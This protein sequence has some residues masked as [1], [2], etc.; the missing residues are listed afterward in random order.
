MEEKAFLSGNESI[1]RG[2]YEGGGVIATGCPGVPITESLRTI[3]EKYKN[4][5]SEMSINENVALEVSIGASIAGARA[6]TIM[7]HT[8]LNIALDSL[9][10]FTQSYINGGF[11]IAISS[12]AGGSNS[13]TNQDV[14][15]LGKYASIGIFAPSNQQE[16]KDFIKISLEVSEKYSSPIMLLVNTSICQ[17][18]SMVTLKNRI[19]SMMK[20]FIPDQTKY[21]MFPP[22]LSQAQSRLRERVESL[23]NYAYSCELNILEEVS[24][25][26]TLIIT[27][28]SLY[29]LLKEINPKVSIYKLGCIYPISIKK[30]KELSEK[31]TNIIIL[32]ES[33]PFIENE[34]KFKGIQCEGKKYFS[35]DGTFEIEDIYKG[36]IDAGVIQVENTPEQSQ[37]QSSEQNSQEGQLQNQDSEENIGESSGENTG[38]IEDSS[39][40]G[41]LQEEESL[42]G[43]TVTL[44]Q[45]ELS[46]S[47]LKENEGD[48]K[49]E[50]SEENKDNVTE[51]IKEGINKEGEDKKKQVEETAGEIISKEE[52]K[53]NIDSDTTTLNFVIDLSKKPIQTNLRGPAFFAGCPYLPIMNMLKKLK[54]LVIGDIGC[55]TISTYYPWNL[56]QITMNLGSSMGVI[57][58]MR[59]VF[60]RKGI[61]KPLVAIIGDGSFFHS[62]I[63]GAI[64]LLNEYRREEN[65][66]VIILDNKSMASG[67]W[68]ESPGVKGSCYYEIKSLNNPM[69]NNQKNSYLEIDKILKAFGFYD[70]SVVDQFRYKDTMKV[71]KQAIYRPGISIIVA[72]RPCVIAN[73]VQSPHLVVL[74]TACRG[75]GECLS[76]HCQAIRMVKDKE[77]SGV[78]AYID[79]I[80]CNGCSVCLEVCPYKAIQRMT[81]LK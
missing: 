45:E 13:Y 5:Y 31:Y 44:A 3:A 7:K 27:A 54:V 36:L 63:L 12:D 1:A 76:L 72:K 69:G 18:K 57:K 41:T 14:R 20:G 17:G 48:A 77:V 79:P 16:T 70:I 39:I 81:E 61:D 59:K 58:G 52:I 32:E 22:Y 65:I 15:I 53:F 10:T 51:E 25:V 73:K 23:E 33:Y 6:I 78:K 8:G 40:E 74:R 46:K 67:E 66:T 24:G 43:Q 9:M 11:L 19:Q 62:G 35:Y 4:I 28:S 80:I 71:I 21:V 30:V 75:C 68:I 49:D 42:G 60:H 29:C 37:N 38:E 26:T 2:F 47:D 55:Q 56:S 50:E 34:L 64:N